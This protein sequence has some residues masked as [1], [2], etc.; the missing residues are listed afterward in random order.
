MTRPCLG[1]AWAAYWCGS[2][3]SC[4]GWQVRRIAGEYKAALARE[5]RPGR[6]HSWLLRR[7]LGLA[8]APCS[9]VWLEA[10][11]VAAS[12]EDARLAAVT[13]LKALLTTA[14]KQWAAAA[15]ADA[16]TQASSSAGAITVAAAQAA[17]GVLA[18]ALAGVAAT[19]RDL[20][21]AVQAAAA[22]A[23]AVDAAGA[24]LSNAAEAAYILLLL[25]QRWSGAAEALSTAEADVAAG[26]AAAL[27]QATG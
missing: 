10:A 11:S 15:A 12:L 23:A 7:E 8:S 20:S 14:H 1:A 25:V 21:D 18:E 9:A 26:L 24:H 5:G 22:E 6:V 16:S 4:V 19:A 3:T 13:A 2:S 27:L 17:L